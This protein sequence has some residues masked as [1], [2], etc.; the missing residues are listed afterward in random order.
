MRS[1]TE[2]RSEDVLMCPYCGFE[3]HSADDLID[4]DRYTHYTCG[5]CGKTFEVHKKQ[6]TIFTSDIIT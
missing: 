1:R 2:I 6:I 4:N 5:S 3:D